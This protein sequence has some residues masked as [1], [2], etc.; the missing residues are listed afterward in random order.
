MRYRSRVHVIT[1]ASSGIGAALALQLAKRKQRIVLAARSEGA[2]EHVAAE[3]RKRGG[4]ATVVPTDVT[5]DAECRRLMTRAIEDFGAIDVL[6]NNAGLSMHA[7]FDEI[8]DFSTFERLWRVNC[9]GTILCTRHAYPYLRAGPSKRGGQIVGI[10]SLAAKTGVPGR[11]VYCMSKYAQTGFLEALRTEAADDG[12]AITIAYPGVVNT[13]IR[14]HGLNGR[15]EPAGISMLEEA[16]AM[17]VDVCARLIFDAMR[18]RKRECV[19]T[20]QGKIGVWLKLIA[21][22]LVDRMARA[23]VVTK[24]AQQSG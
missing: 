7:R 3:C 9:L 10:S 19:M 13:E 2:L 5:S 1:G 4:H 8:T 23:K 11:T 20:A 6:I 17:P 22:G 15:G 21:P 24:A 14:R 12:I 18:K 16:N